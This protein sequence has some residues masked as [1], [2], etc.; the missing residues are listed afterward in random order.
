[1]FKK[2]I[3]IVLMMLYL[4]TV[5]G[6]AVNL[7]YCF[8]RVS[9]IQIDA[10][11]KGCVKGLETREMKCCKDKH[12]VVKVKDAHQNGSFSFVS[13]VF[14]ADVPNLQFADLPITGLNPAQFTTSYRGPPPLPDN[15]I[16]LKNCTFRI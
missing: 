10:P 8:N 15:A 9:S 13:K 12:L 16:Y 2:P 14:I 11:S 4:V 7:H 1:M 3:V 6:F 5:S